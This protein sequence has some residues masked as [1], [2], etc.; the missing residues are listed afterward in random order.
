MHCPHGDVGSED[1]EEMGRVSIIRGQQI[2][3]TRV[4]R[5]GWS[6]GLPLR[7]EEGMIVGLQEGG[8]FVCC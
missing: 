2:L 1:S 5:R 6:F 8:L 3:V 7:E 4:G